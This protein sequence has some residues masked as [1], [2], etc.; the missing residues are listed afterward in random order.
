M[1]KKL[2]TFPIK[3][4]EGE[5]TPSISFCFPIFDNC[6]EFVYASTCLTCNTL[7]HYFYV[8]KNIKKINT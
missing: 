6:S 4:L 7:L 1:S 3:V 2:H 5:S 8:K